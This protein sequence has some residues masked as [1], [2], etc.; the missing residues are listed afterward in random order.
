MCGLVGITEKK[1]IHVGGLLLLGR[2]CQQ[3]QLARTEETPGLQGQPAWLWASAEAVIC[4]A[5]CLAE[6]DEL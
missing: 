4:H 5:P 6:A 3:S 2:Q 1:E